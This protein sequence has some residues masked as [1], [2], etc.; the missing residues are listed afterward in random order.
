MLTIA[1]IAVPGL[2]RSRAAASAASTV[3]SMRAVQTAQTAYSIMYAA[4]GYAN[5]IVKLGPPKGA[6]PVTP[7]RA[8]L[9]DW[10]SDCTSQPCAKSGYNFAIEDAVGVPVIAYTLTAAPNSGGGSAIRS[11]CMNQDGVMAYDPAGGGKCGERLQHAPLNT[12]ESSQNK[13]NS[14]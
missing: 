9:L 13:P 6:N 3:A 2:L 4:S 14:N 5:D 11:Y 7:D 12:D 1:G 10:L 8:G